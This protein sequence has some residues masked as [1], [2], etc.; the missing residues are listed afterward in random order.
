MKQT[1]SSPTKKSNKMKKEESK[2]LYE[3]L[4]HSDFTLCTYFTLKNCGNQ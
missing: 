2:I 4:F 3:D 1:S